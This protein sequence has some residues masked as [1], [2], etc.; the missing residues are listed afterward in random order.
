[1]S[2]SLATLEDVV[3]QINERGTTF[4]G[5]SLVAFYGVGGSYGISLPEEMLWQT[6]EG[7]ELS[8]GYVMRALEAF[9]TRILAV[10]RNVEESR[11]D[12]CL[13]PAPLAEPR[14]YE[15]RY[16]I[17]CEF[18]IVSWTEV[19]ATDLADAHGEAA[20]APLPPQSEWQYLEGSF[21]INPDRT[22]QFMTEHGWK[23]QRPYVEAA[24]VEASE[25]SG[26]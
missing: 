7:E 1:M 20:I 21:V 24:G 3:D 5:S 22:A 26:D 10:T 14:S 11:V 8:L 25:D 12:V 23:E 19:N 16:R 2:E 17:P 18:T 9:A 13:G 4:S 15:F 6:E